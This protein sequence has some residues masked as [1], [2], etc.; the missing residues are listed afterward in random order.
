MALSFLG[1]FLRFRE[2]LEAFGRDKYQV[3]IFLSFLTFLGGAFFFFNPILS[4]VL[5]VV[6]IL[7]FL[8]IPFL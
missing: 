1:L 2:A 7:G 6:T 3:F 5:L 4:A 8:V